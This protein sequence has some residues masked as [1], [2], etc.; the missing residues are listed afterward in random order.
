MISSYKFEL[1]Q[2]N[3]IGELNVIE[4]PKKVFIFVFLDRISNF[5]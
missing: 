4:I 5:L 2:I 1:L 3:G